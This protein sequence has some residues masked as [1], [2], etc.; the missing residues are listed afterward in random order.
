MKAQLA[1]R[2]FVKLLLTLPAVYGWVLNIT[3]DPAETEVGSA[4]KRV[5]RKA[6]PDKGGSNEDSQRLREKG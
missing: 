1:K 3:R 4:F 6:Y 5:A 2:A